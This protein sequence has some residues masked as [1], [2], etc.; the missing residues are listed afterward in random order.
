M[1]STYNGSCNGT[2]AWIMLQLCSISVTLFVE[3]LLLKAQ[4][5]TLRGPFFGLR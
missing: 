5:A 1:L 2:H 4:E 3:F